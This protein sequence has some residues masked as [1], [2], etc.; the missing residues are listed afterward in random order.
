M[1]VA[2]QLGLNDPE[3]ALLAQARGQWPTWCEQHSTL[4]VVDDLLE[5]PQWLK[6]APKTSADDV[7]HT[8]AT[9][10]SPTGGD[11]VTAAGA[12]AWALL[13]AACL[14]AHRLRSLTSRI[15]EVVAAQLWL[16]VR[17][18]PWERQ[19]KVAANIT[20]NTRRGVLRHLEVGNHAR[21]VDPAWAR[22]IP[23]APTADLWRTLEARAHRA[24]T[25]AGIELAQAFDWALQ[26]GAIDQRDLHLLINLA[27]TADEAGVARAGCGQGGLCSRGVA[28]TVAARTGLSA[29]TVRRRASASL[30]AVATVCA[31]IPA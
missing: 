7:L 15:D 25:P 8:L 21:Q 17:G 9:L 13:P 28:R 31:Q 16:E 18:F 5:L 12:L 20:M 1:S 26:Q 14:L 4:Q 3:Q 27:V 22:S 10:A 23:L 2:T 29:A 6:Q 30:R 19:R 11:D 24:D